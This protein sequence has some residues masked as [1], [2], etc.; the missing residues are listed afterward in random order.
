MDFYARNLRLALC[1]PPSPAGDETGAM[2]TIEHLLTS[3]SAAGAHLAVLPELFLPGYNVDDIPARAQPIDGP[4]ITDLCRMTRAAE[5]G[6]V[7]GY[8]EREGDQIFNSVVAIGA[9]GTILANHRKLQLYGQREARIFDEGSELV[10]FEMMDQQLSLLICYDVEFSHHVRALALKGAEIV[11]APSA[12]ESPYVTDFLVR[13]HAVT[14]GVI[15]AYVNYCGAEGNQTYC[16]NSAVFGQ[17]GAVLASAGSAPALLM[18]D[19]PVPDL[20]A[21]VASHLTDHRD[22]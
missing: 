16:G 7:V 10:T 21:D 2:A 15:I 3:A 12:N 1:Q 8:A 17:D 14:N 11:I 5:C 18:V 13:G 4:W 6:L 22:L 19:L 9:D 20:P